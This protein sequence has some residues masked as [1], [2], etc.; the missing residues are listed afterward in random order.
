MSLP[1]NLG[2]SWTDAAVLGHDFNGS[3]VE[4][5]RLS[6]NC[7]KFQL[8]KH[9]SDMRLPDDHLVTRGLHLSQQE[10]GATQDVSYETELAGVR[11]PWY[12]CTDE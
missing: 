7:Q 5:G 4:I 8:S 12:A 6:E 2:S 10:T 11:D 3:N 1:T 9:T